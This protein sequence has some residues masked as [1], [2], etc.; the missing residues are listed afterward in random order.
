[1]LNRAIQAQ[2][3]PG[4]TFK[5]I[6]ALAALESG[7]V[8]DAFKAHCPGGASF[9]GRYFKCWQKGGHGVVD[10]HKAITHSCDV[11]F[12][13]IGNKMGIDTIAKYAEMAGLGEKSG[14][15]LPNEATGVM[16]STK[17][18]MRNF[19][20]KWYAG[21][22]I[23]VSIGQGAVTVTP[24]QLA[25]AIG[26]IATGGV[27]QRPHLVKENSKGG[28]DARKADLNIDNVLKVINGMYSV[29][30]EGG[31]GIRARLPGIE[32][33][34]KTGSAQVVSNQFVRSAG[35]GGHPKDNAWFVGFAPRQS[36][37]IVVV[38]MWEGG[39]HG[40]LA[41][42]IARDIIKAYFD[43]KARLQRPTQLLAH[44]PSFG[45]ISP[46]APS[47]DSATGDKTQPVE[48]IE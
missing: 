48:E 1:M 17:W 20:Q 14:I 30:N 28:E 44:A 47:S 33:C 12:Y 24:L 46:A 40:M 25:R 10:L 2:L 26:G 8:D 45:P 16:P 19:R 7:T 11:Y 39:E 22:T 18:K 31:T 6:M 21:E 27:W 29:V 38:S 13:T 4:S 36:P 35:K 34:G 15:D 37:E 41:A 5:P 9:Y 3:A 23:S 42:P 32:V 43:K